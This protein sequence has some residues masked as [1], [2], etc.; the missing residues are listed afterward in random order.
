MS[1]QAKYDQFQQTIESLN[2]K[3]VQLHS[4][5]DEHGIVLATLKEVPPDRKCYRMVGGSLVELVAGNATKILE[6]NL[7]GM[8]KSVDTLTEEL[9]KQQKEFVDWKEKNNIKIVKAN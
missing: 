6:E 4:Q 7:D 5:I 2:T 1:L 8:K 9:K 3:I